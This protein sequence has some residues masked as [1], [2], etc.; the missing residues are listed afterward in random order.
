M[1]GQKPQYY[2]DTLVD[3]FYNVIDRNLNII[4]NGQLC[5]APVCYFQT[6]LKVWRP[7][8]APT[9]EFG[10]AT[11]DY[12]SLVK[13]PSDLFAHDK[14]LIEPAKRETTEEFL[15]CQA[16]YRPVVII[17]QSKGRKDIKEARRGHK[18]NHDILFVVPLYSL[19]KS[20]SDKCRFTN[21]AI[22]NIRLLQYFNLL[23]I[24]NLS[25]YEI[26]D[27][28]IRIDYV[29]SI[30]PELVK[31]IPL[32]LSNDP[33]SIIQQMLVAIITKNVSRKSELAAYVEMLRNQF[34]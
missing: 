14:P 15:F 32:R 13:N 22:E 34:N 11:A 16:K 3:D 27:S 2:F 24:P 9:N 10:F 18:F 20:N 1:K 28:I 17:G 7:D 25:T 23:F 5:W 6:E 12:F 33:L 30:Y 19:Y 4:I 8:Y 29:F 26:K 31:P 21:E